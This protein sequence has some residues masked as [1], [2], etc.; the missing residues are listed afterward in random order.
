[1]PWQA[2]VTKEFSARFYRVLGMVSGSRLADKVRMAEVIDIE[3]LKNRA[4]GLRDWLLKKAPEC[5]TEQK[6]TEEGT[7][8]RIYW[9]YGY[10]VAMRDIYQLLTGQGIPTQGHSSEPDRNAKSPSA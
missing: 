3:V 8:E 7:Q 9:H 10:L 4:D 2:I 1:M 5:F 6:H